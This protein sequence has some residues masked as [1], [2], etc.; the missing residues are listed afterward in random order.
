M[1]LVV[2]A[3]VGLDIGHTSGSG[4]VSY[5]R[6]QLRCML[7]FIMV[8]TFLHVCKKSCCIVPAGSPMATPP[9]QCLA[10]WPLTWQFAYLCHLQCRLAHRAAGS[11]THSATPYVSQA[12]RCHSLC[13]LCHFLSLSVSAWLMCCM[14]LYCTTLQAWPQHGSLQRRQLQAAAEGGG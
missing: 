9:A 5:C 1:L 11:A 14:R 4:L 8:I 7:A 13:S 6:S 12:T 10:A 2:E 3:N